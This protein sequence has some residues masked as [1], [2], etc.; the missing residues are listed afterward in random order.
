MFTWAKSVFRAFWVA[1][2]ATIFKWQAPADYL[3][4]INPDCRIPERLNQQ[5]GG[6]GSVRMGGRCH[7]EV[8]ME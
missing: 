2:K 8:N 4:V 7:I 1:K 5:V 3:Y 6:G